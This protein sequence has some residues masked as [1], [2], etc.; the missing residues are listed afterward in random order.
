MDSW[1]G[2]KNM[3][4]FYQLMKKIRQKEAE[5]IIFIITWSGIGLCGYWFFTPYIDV[6]IIVITAIWIE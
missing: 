6:F 4:I 1:K 3:V 5:F 2:I